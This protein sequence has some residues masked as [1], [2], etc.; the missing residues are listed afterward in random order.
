MEKLVSPRTVGIFARGRRTYGRNLPPAFYEK[1]IRYLEHMNYNVIWLGDRQSVPVCPLP[2]VLDFAHSDESRDLEKTLAIICHLEF[3][4]QFWTASSRLAGMM[5]VPYILFES[6]EQILFSGML[7]GQEGK[8]LELTTFGSKKVVL[9]HYLSVLEHQDK[10]L[11]LVGQA[12][13]ELHN[14][15]EEYL[16]G[17]V[18]NPAAIQLLMKNIGKNG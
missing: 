15:N 2:H 12:I 7:A 14:G 16:V 5:G 6:P 1:L 17:L 3:T 10:T 8:R 4:I 13:E 9:A 11:D 18:E